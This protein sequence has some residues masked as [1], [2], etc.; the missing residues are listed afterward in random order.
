MT[1]PNLY[2]PDLNPTYQDFAR[3][4]GVAVVPTRVRKPRDKAKVET[5]VQVVERWILARLRDHKFFSLA[6]L[7][8]PMATLLA[9]LNQR[10]MKHLGQS[11]LEL[12]QELDKPMLSAL[13]QQPYE[14]AVCPVPWV[15]GHGRKKPAS[16]LITQCSTHWTVPRGV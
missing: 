9:E 15:R 1:S 3:H 12:F 5:G 6:E 8:Q 11:R 7:N 16:I 13:P 10:E 14:L 2:E 4:Y